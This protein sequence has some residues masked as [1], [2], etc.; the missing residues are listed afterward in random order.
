MRLSPKTMSLIYFLLGSVFTYMAV[1]SA[2]DTVWNFMT[3]LLAF[4]ATID[5]GV[6]IRMLILHFKLKQKNK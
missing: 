3:I 6:G 1:Q 4:F 5:F 2:E